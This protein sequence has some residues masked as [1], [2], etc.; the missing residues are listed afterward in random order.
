MS[1]A[2]PQATVSL[3]R[4]ELE[5]IF[6]ALGTTREEHS[7]IPEDEAASQSAQSKIRTATEVLAKRRKLAEPATEATP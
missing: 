3:T 2:T 4:D 1:E 5:A 7:L 6:W